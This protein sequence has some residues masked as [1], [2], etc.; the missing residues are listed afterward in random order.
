MVVFQGLQLSITHQ[1]LLS[2][3][4]A[5][6]KDTKKNLKTGGVLISFIFC[7]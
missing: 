4:I 6:N 7:L 3:T 5:L 2:L 1:Y